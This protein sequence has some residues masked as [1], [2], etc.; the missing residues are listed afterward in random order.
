M[1]WLRAP[2]RPEGQALGRTILRVLLILA[3]GGVTVSSPRPAMAAYFGFG[4]CTT[5][6]AT[7][8]WWGCQPPFSSDMEKYLLEDIYQN[9]IVGEWWD[10]E[11]KPALQSM[12]AQL[13]ASVLH[14]AGIIGTFYDGLLANQTKGDNL[15]SLNYLFQLW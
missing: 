9:M 2:R 11:F 4:T 5:N 13:N 12:S 3:L 7:T 15:E 1:G 14:Q 8:T 6:L 10:T